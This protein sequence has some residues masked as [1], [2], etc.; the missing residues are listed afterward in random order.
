MPTSPT[1]ES[2]PRL[3]ATIETATKPQTQKIKVPSINSK[4]A[5]TNASGP[6][7]P[8]FVAT[9][10]LSKTFG[11]LHSIV[12]DTLPELKHINVL[13]LN[14]RVLFLPIACIDIN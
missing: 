7:I 9:L 14:A 3:A 4:V 12:V 6:K 1:V 5:K 13:T 2:R 10:I 11:H 8:N